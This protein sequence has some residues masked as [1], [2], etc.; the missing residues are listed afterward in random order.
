VGLKIRSPLLTK[1]AGWTAA[2][3]FRSLFRTL[4]LDIELEEGSID[5]RCSESRPALFSLWHDSILIPLAHKC[6]L[7]ANNI[8]ALASRHQDGMY[9]VEFMNHIGVR[10]IRGSTNHG[11]VRALRELIREANHSHIFITPDG[12]RGPRRVMKDGILFLA[13]QTGLPI[14]PVAST[15]LNGW[16]IQGSWTDLAIPKPFS[17]TVCI[18][19]P[20]ISIPPDLSRDDLDLCRERVQREMDRLEARV[21]AKASGEFTSTP[22]RR[23]A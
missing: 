11:G 21:Q 23:A 2:M 9:L 8:S 18:V 20:A 5:P 10:S 15:C 17:R 7:R 22:A 13:S 4:D 16:S 12:P 6:R 19:G 1:T 14:T 3:V